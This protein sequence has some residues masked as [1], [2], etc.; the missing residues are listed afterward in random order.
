MS[1]G[2]ARILKVGQYSNSAG[3]HHP[4]Y[5]FIF[6]AGGNSFSNVFDEPKLVE[7]MGDEMGL[8]SD[9]IDQALSVL[10]RDG[11]VTIPD[12]ELSENHAAALGLQEVG[13]DY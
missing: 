8:R 11:H 12:V 7:L 1:T 4:Q 13:S 10:R 6:N 2:F 5:Q 9:V 3:L